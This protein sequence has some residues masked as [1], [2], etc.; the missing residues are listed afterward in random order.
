[1]K[2]PTC[3]RKLRR[4]GKWGVISVAIGPM[5]AFGGIYTCKRRHVWVWCDPPVVR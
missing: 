5:I 4:R 3:E 2:C 1:V